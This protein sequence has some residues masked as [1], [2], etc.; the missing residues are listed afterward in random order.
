MKA[1]LVCAGPSQGFEDLVAEEALSADLVVAVDGGS[2]LCERAGVSPSAVVGD[3]DSISHE[4]VDR[5][6][7][8]GA[9]L[10]GFPADKDVSD[11][12]LALD[13][14]RRQGVTEVAV[15]AAFSGRLDHT[16][17]A[18]GSL[19]RSADLCPRLVEPRLKGWV[20]ASERHRSIVVSGP[21]ETF[22][23]IALAAEA[24]VSVS[25]ARWELDRY[26]L[27]PLDTKGLS[28][29]VVGAGALV[30]VHSGVA[31]VVCPDLSR[32]DESAG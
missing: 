21:G 29:R 13:F 8:G 31:V 9:H 7:A 12:D 4:D 10:V 15:C 20:L 19:A 16:L 1:L 26:G 23:V 5:L 27:S 25:G 24:T 30:Q 22:S 11:L 28:N 14:V 32:K 3:F 17:V 18:L 2:L 6:S